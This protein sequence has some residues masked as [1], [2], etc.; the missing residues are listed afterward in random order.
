MVG[1]TTPPSNRFSADDPDDRGVA[2]IPSEHVG[3]SAATGRERPSQAATRVAY[4][5]LTTA[6]NTTTRHRLTGPAPRGPASGEVTGA[7]IDG[8]AVLDRR[9]LVAD[10]ETDKIVGAKTLLVSVIYPQDVTCS[11]AFDYELIGSNYSGDV[12]AYLAA[13][14]AIARAFWAE[15][16]WGT[17]SVTATYACRADLPQSRRR[18][19]LDG[20]W[21]MNAAMPRDADI[22]WRC[23]TATPRPR[24]ERSVNRSDAAAAN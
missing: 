11:T 20:P 6:D 14:V 15:N 13:D 22:P 10:K 18:G 19:Y 8:V 9:T 3:L 2:A 1:Q 17:F 16:S 4:A 24:R 23:I 5:K 21:R 7:I 12:L